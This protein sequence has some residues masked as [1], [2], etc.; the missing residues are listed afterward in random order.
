MTQ[1]EWVLK[2]RKEGRRSVSE[3]DEDTNDNR[4]NVAISAS[5]GGGFHFDVCV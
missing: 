4:R 2:E 3:E 5:T 1:E